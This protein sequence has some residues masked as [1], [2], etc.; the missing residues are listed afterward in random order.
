MDFRP[1]HDHVIVEAATSKTT[2]TKGG[3]LLPDIAKEKPLEGKVVA[4]GPGYRNKTGEVRSLAVK[5]GDRVVYGKWSGTEVKIEDKEYLIVKESDIL[6]VI[7]GD[8]KI[9]VRAKKE[10]SDAAAA[11]CTIDHVHDDGCCDD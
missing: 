2:K 5:K 10:D 11:A 7:E 1:L 6:G 3:I 9:S 8:G 4:V